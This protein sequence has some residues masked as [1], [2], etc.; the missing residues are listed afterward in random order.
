MPISQHDT[1]VIV[2]WELLPLTN[3]KECR[4][5]TKPS[6]RVIPLC[7]VCCDEIQTLFSFGAGEGGRQSDKKFKCV[8]SFCSL[9]DDCC[10]WVGLDRDGWRDNGMGHMKKKRVLQK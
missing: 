10:R 3:R 1:K 9:F 2:G 8:Y 7:V 4:H 6:K 5:E